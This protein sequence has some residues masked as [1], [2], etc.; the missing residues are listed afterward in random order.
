[1]ASK[2]II[3]RYLDS[4]AKEFKK[5]RKRS[6]KWTKKIMNADSEIKKNFYKRITKG[7]KRLDIF[8]KIVFVIFVFILFWKKAKNPE[9]L[10]KTEK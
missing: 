1:M 9:F 5:S 2:G 7:P 8:I 4:Y 10:E 3:E 6:A